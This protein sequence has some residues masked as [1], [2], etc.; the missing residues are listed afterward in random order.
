M[1]FE[2]FYREFENRHRGSR[3]EIKSR[4]EFYLPFIEPLKNFYHDDLTALDL[5]C[6]RGEWI[7]LLRDIGFSATG[8]DI[9]QQMIDDCVALK[10][11]VIREDAVGYLKSLPDNSQHVVSAFHLIEHLPFESIVSLTE[12]AL[13]VLKPAGIMILETPNSENIVVGTSSFYMD[14][15]HIRP[16]PSELVA[17]LVGHLGFSRHLT[18]RLQEPPDIFAKEG[19]GLIDV[20]TSVSPDYGV[21]AQKWARQEVRCSFDGVFAGQHGIN[22]HTAA[23]RYDRDISM[24]FE[25]IGQTLDN[26][27]QKL[28][29][30]HEQWWRDQIAL[31]EPIKSSLQSLADQMAPRTAQAEREAEVAH[32]MR[33]EAEDRAVRAEQE[34]EV[35]HAMRLEAEDRA[36]RAKQ[37]AEAT[38]QSWSWRITAPLRGLL[39]LNRFL[40]RVVFSPI[41]LFRY[42]LNTLLR[43]LTEKNAGLIRRVAVALRRR[44]SLLRLADRTLLLFP[45]WRQQ[46]LNITQESASRSTD[47]DFTESTSIAEHLPRNDTAALRSHRAKKIHADLEHAIAKHETKANS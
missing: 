24:A 36:V 15:T 42:A 2:D 10:L 12:E 21:V 28:T 7:E 23:A 46:I 35:A 38:R 14:P 31:I 8:V 25:K 5:G 39:D 11:P 1:N 47:F 29:E 6:G 13:R 18:V 32:A 43:H 17:Y 37:E 40:L 4:V 19:I 26:T 16:L 41:R 27:S 33:L 44:P 20:I 3:E 34:A 9:N 22:L 30:V 45:V